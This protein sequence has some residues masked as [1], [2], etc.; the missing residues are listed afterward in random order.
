MSLLEI[1]NEE[2][3]DLLSP[4][5]DVTERLQLFDDPRN[6]VSLC[7]S[8]TLMLNSLSACFRLV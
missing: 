2:L 1:Y 7:F 6:K 5:E 8:S 4:S 3:F